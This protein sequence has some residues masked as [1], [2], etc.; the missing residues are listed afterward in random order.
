MQRGK[1]SP[2]KPSPQK[3]KGISY[4]NHFPS[5]FLKPYGRVHDN[6]EENNMLDTRANPRSCEWFLRP[7][8]AVSE[9]AQ[10]MAENLSVLKD[11]EEDTI[12]RN[13]KCQPLFQQI[14][15]VL[16]SFNRLNSKDESSGNP[17]EADI[18]NLLKFLLQEN[19]QLDELMA[20]FYRLGGAMFLSSTHYFVAQRVITDPKTY[21]LKI[22]PEESVESIET[23]KRKGDLRSL[24][25]M[26][27]DMC[28]KNQDK[29]KAG[30]TSTQSERKNLMA[31]FQAMLEED[32]TDKNLPSMSNDD[33]L[34]PPHRGSVKRKIDVTD[35]D[36]EDDN[37]DNACNTG[38][39]LQ[40][41]LDRLKKS[42]APPNTKGEAK[43]K[44]KK[45]K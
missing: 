39:I 44:K 17:T 25:H 11:D 37:K 18:N 26:L 21:S 41:K 36:D 24:K 33:I 22:T 6:I 15:Q 4:F 1:K 5:N 34:I 2:Y 8:F 14:Q 20:K 16:P 27:T 9:F 31:E 35:S 32:S 12:I 28:L 23:F 7:D 43:A 10:T 30:N 3:Q 42:I 45:S 38:R 40:N 19:L 29:T 13:R